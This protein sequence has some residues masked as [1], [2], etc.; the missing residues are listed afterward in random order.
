MKFK[1]ELLL[2]LSLGLL[3]FQSCTSP[4]IYKSIWQ[5]KP[6]SIDGK[7]TE[8]KIPL[9]YFDDKSKLNFSVSNDNKN[10][11]I[12]VRATEE[13][14]QKGIIRNGLQIW[15]DTVGGK[16]NQVGIQFP[17]VQIRQKETGSAGGQPGEISGAHSL[18]SQYSGTPRQIKLT[19]FTGV[20]S[21]FAETPNMYGINACLNWDTNN[22]MIYEACIPFGTFFKA[23]LS[24]SDSSKK[25]SGFRSL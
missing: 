3:L 8:W 24:P 18:K 13:E 10:I 7:A 20:P 11:Y 16:K 22:I 15:F 1:N 12:C 2:F 4:L 17:I 5:D 6:V 9:D 21:G 14:T 19:G 25:F 23:T